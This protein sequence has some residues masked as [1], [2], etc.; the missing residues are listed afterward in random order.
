MPSQETYDAFNSFIFSNDSKVFGK[1]LAR[2]AI[3]EATMTVPGDIVECGVFKGSG[4]LTWLKLKRALFPNA[5]KKVIGFDYFNTESLLNSLS[6]DE[7][8]RMGELFDSRGYRHS[9]R[10]EQVIAMSIL[11]AGF[12]THDFDL[13]KGNI[14]VTAP[15]YVAKKPGFKISVLYMDMDLAGATYDALAVFWPYVSKGG[16]VVFDEYAYHEWSESQGVDRFFKDLD[17]QIKA[18]HCECPTAYIRKP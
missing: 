5:H 6:D 17:V 11:K 1:L 10:A 9:D 2:S 4:L 14:S 12:A 7:R 16:L 8:Y 3:A 13:V 15:E 18:L